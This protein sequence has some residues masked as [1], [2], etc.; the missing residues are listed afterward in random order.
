MSRSL[1]PIAWPVAVLVIAFGVHRLSS[2]HS[3]PRELEQAPARIPGGSSLGAA[4]GDLLTLRVEWPDTESVRTLIVE[5][6]SGEPVWILMETGRSTK[7]LDLE[8]HQ[9]GPLRVTRSARRAVLL[10]GDGTEVARI[11]IDPDIEDVQIIR[12]N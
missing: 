7:S 8:S 1:R 9:A 12:P 11:P 6:G 4:E 3:A 5:D 2:N 10:D